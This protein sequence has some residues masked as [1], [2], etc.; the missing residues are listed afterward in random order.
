MLYESWEM[1]RATK[2]QSFTMKEKQ[3]AI[4]LVRECGGN[5]ACASRMLGIDR[6]S[7][8]EWIRKEE[9]IRDA[10]NEGRKRLG[11][12]GRRAF[13][14]E[15]EERMLAWSRQELQDERNGNCLNYKVIQN[16]GNELAQEMG[17]KNFKCS[18]KWIFNFIQRNHLTTK[19]YRSKRK[20]SSAVSSSSATSDVKVSV[21]VSA[22]SSNKVSPEQQP[23][24]DAA[25]TSTLKQATISSSLPNEP[26]ENL[27]AADPNGN[28]ST[29]SSTTVPIKDVD[30]PTEANGFTALSQDSSA[31][32]C[33]SLTAEAAETLAQKPCITTYTSQDMQENS[34]GQI[35]QVSTSRTLEEVVATI[36]AKRRYF[37]RTDNTESPCKSTHAEKHQTSA[38]DTQ[39]S[40][41]NSKDGSLTSVKA[42][43]NDSCEG[44]AYDIT[45]NLAIF[46]NQCTESVVQLLNAVNKNYLH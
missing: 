8:R 18:N 25:V 10:A 24:G 44:A 19:G 27:L 14:P 16:R 6:T 4:A 42:P 15:L 46:A 40:A 43:L 5:L 1:M 28:S 35:Q 22:Q 23:T 12:A 9:T 30:P 39:T 34:N 32:T 41:V 33:L 3:A 26:A 11:S 29:F 7:L 13:W 45:N 31:M 36:K 17:I 21:N 2:R 37:V 20:R 38:T